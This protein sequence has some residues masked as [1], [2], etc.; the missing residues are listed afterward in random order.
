MFLFQYV[1]CLHVFLCF[2]DGDIPVLANTQNITGVG[3]RSWH[4]FTSNGESF[5]LLISNAR[6]DPLITGVNSDGSEGLPDSSN[7]MGSMLFRWQGV[8]I[9]VQVSASSVSEL[10]Y[11]QS[12]KIFCLF[13]TK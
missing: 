2:T 8:F 12:L 5:L 9:P 7:V 6:T 4:S 11:P 1:W 10:I 3:V 13:V